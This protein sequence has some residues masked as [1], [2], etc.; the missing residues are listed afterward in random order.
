MAVTGLDFIVFGTPHSVN[1]HNTKEKN[2]WMDKVRS[3]AEESWR[4]LGL[5]EPVGDDYVA[6]VIITHYANSTMDVDNIIK[7][8][9]D[10]VRIPDAYKER[11]RRARKRR[12]ALLAP[13]PFHIFEDDGIVEEV[14]CRR[15]GLEGFTDVGNVSAALAD[16]L[17]KGLEFV[18]VVVS[19]AESED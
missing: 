12:M 4:L 15:V 5:D 10:A 1:N 11:V 17:G 8:I 3:A 7:E 6:R 14:R 19:W 9:V 13:P 18:H 16:A 2:K